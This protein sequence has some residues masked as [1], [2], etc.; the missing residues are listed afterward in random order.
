MKS[1]ANMHVFLYWNSMKL[2]NAPSAPSPQ[3]YSLADDH[4]K[5]VN[6]IER[7]WPLSIRVNNC[8]ANLAQNGLLLRR[9]VALHH[10]EHIDEVG[11]EHELLVHGEIEA[12]VAGYDRR[13]ECRICR[14]IFGLFVEQ[15]LVGS[16]EQV[17]QVELVKVGFGWVHKHVV[18]YSAK[19]NLRRCINFNL[20]FKW[21]VVS[22]HKCVT[23]ELNSFFLSLNKAPN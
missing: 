15:G 12:V 23:L 10:I 13:Q 8:L 22:V 5:L 4:S 19:W 3:T 6:Q 11:L 9:K 18:W 20:W 21:L 1:D 16:E 7:N 2:K 14:V 17:V